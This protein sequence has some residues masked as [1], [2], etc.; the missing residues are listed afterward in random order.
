LHIFPQSGRPAGS[1]VISDEDA[2][3]ILWICSGR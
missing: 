1:I 3:N 2:A